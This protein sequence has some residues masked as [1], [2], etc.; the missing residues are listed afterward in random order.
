MVTGKSGHVAAR[1]TA[2]GIGAAP[3]WRPGAGQRVCAEPSLRGAAPPSG[4]GG[5]RR[6]VFWEHGGLRRAGLLPPEM[7]AAPCAGRSVKHIPGFKGRWVQSPLSRLLADGLLTSVSDR[8]L[9]S[10]HPV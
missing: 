3:G 5:A 7:K 9:H 2:D 4:S 10:L 6:F 8:E 1:S